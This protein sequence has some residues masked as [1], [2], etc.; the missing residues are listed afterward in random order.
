MNENLKFSNEQI[1]QFAHD[2]YDIIVQDI[3]ECR[4]KEKEENMRNGG[5]VDKEDR[6]IA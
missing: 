2:W 4:E 5:Y 1:R 3:K 6:K